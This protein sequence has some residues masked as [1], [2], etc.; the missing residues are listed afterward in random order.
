MYIVDEEGIR[1]TRAQPV[2]VGTVESTEINAH[3]YIANVSKSEEGFLNVN[4]KLNENVVL[5]YA[6]NGQ[7]Y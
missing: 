5:K 3:N 1:V 6:W 2:K 4:S 7:T